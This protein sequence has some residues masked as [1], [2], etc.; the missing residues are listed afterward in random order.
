MQQAQTTATDERLLVQTTTELAACRL[1]SHDSVV[2]PSLVLAALVEAKHSRL[3]AVHWHAQVAQLAALGSQ[4]C[5]ERAA[6]VPCHS[7]TQ[8][9]R[10]C[11]V[12]YA[13][14]ISLL[15]ASLLLL[16][17]ELHPVWDCR[18]LAHGYS[19]SFPLRA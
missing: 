17:L 4:R 6:A 16:L 11:V 2:H 10:H 12:E 14:L 15:L 5:T 1:Q 9:H 3:W 8:P 18:L 13:L 19:S 7:E